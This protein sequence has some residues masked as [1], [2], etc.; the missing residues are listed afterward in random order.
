MPAIV[1]IVKIDGVSQGAIVQFGDALQ[2]RPSSTSKSYAGAGS[3]I[4]GDLA[5][6][7]N[8]ISAT[9]TND[10][11]AVDNSV[12]QAGGGAGGAVV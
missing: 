6:T 9:N 8:G 12:G 1:G 5:R 3:F 7:N 11:D 4:T 2:L 10:P